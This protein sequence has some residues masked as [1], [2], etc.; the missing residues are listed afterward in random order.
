MANPASVQ[1]FSRD[2]TIPKPSVMDNFASIANAMLQ[3]YAK[4]KYDVPQAQLQALFPYLAQQK[5]LNPAAANQPGATQYGGM[6]W[7]VTSPVQDWSDYNSML[8]A[9][10]KLGQLPMTQQDVFK[11]LASAYAMSPQGQGLVTGQVTPQD[12]MSRLMEA[13]TLATQPTKKKTATMAEITAAAKKK[14]I[15]VQEAVN[16][17]RKQGFQITE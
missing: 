2:F 7:N 9:Q 6:P 13:S 12:Y 16:Q 10:D 3:G 4:Q 11:T 15:P 1:S 17:L 8:S 5:M 14:G